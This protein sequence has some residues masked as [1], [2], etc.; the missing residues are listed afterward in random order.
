MAK[1]DP[2]PAVCLHVEIHLTYE[3]GRQLPLTKMQHVRM[4]SEIHCLGRWYAR[5][6]PEQRVGTKGVRT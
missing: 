3:K 4:I 1:I 5:L 6:V 2:A